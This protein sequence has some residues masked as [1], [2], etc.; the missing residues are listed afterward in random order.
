[1]KNILALLAVLIWAGPVQAID[2][3]DCES[4]TLKGS[5]TVGKALCVDHVTSDIDSVMLSVG[6]C[7]GM[8]IDYNSDVAAQ[9]LTMEIQVM[10]CMNPS[11]ADVNNCTPID[12]IDLTGATNFAQMFG[13]KAQWIYIKGDVDPVATTPRTMVL[14]HW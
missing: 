13:A 11:P 8:T 5:I 10:S 2:W 6:K 3:K 14:C 1:M 12:A 7:P 9:V 4:G